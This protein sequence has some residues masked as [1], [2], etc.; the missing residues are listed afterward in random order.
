MKKILIT[1]AGGMLAHDLRAAL[2]ERGNEFQVVAP[3]RAKLDVTNAE[4]VRGVMASYRPAIVFNCAAFTKVDLCETDPRAQVVNAD[5]VASIAASCAKSGARLVHVSTDF[6]FDG[7]KGSPYV[8]EDP[9]NPLSAYGRT[10]REGEERA[11][12]APGAL[13]VRSSWLFGNRG[14]NFVDAMLKQAEEG[15]KTVRVVSDQVGRPTATTDLAEALLALAD[16]RASGIVHYANAGEVSWHEFAREIY[17]LAGH[18]DV[19]VEAITGA[20]LARP[21]IRPAYSVLSTRKYEATTGRVPRDFREPLAEYL[22]RRRA[23]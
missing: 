14:P 7:E 17:R 4:H 1:G 15:K 6:V 2:A 23:P 13:V 21:A 19:D 9:T 11:L 10:K 18:G 20:D 3:T 22:A 5:A 16:A 8:E 12:E